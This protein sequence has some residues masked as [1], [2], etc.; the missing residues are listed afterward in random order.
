M[1]QY[2]VAVSRPGSC[3][4][5]HPGVCGACSG[6]FRLG[7]DGDVHDTSYVILLY[8]YCVSDIVF[9]ILIN[10]Y[11]TFYILNSVFIPVREAPCGQFNNGRR[12]VLL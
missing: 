4:S 9:L 2:R 7:V 12:Y 10:F 1:S 6:G 11:S 5:S 3:R 8:Y